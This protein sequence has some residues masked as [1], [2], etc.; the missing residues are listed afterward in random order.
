M[1]FLKCCGRFCVL[2]D[3]LVLIQIFSIITMHIPSGSTLTLYRGTKVSAKNALSWKS[4]YS[5][6]T[7]SCGISAYLSEIC[8]NFICRLRVVI[9][10]H[11][12]NS[13]AVVHITT[14]L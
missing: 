3:M 8:S 1:K 2:L 11:A 5:G 4:H 7:S 14:K 12:S 9:R 10:A 13:R 6:S